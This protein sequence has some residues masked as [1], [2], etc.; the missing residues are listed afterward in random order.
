MYLYRN[1]CPGKIPFYDED[2]RKARIEGTVVLYVVID[3]RGIPSEVEVFR[4]LSPQ[5]EACDS[6]TLPRAP[7]GANLLLLQLSSKSISSCYET[8]NAS[9]SRRLLVVP[10]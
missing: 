9:P 5:S 8:T 6:G 10:G 3:P 1:W 4:P 7:R 2:S